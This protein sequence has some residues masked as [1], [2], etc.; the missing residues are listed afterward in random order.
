MGT[1]GRI[2]YVTP[3]LEEVDAHSP[4]TLDD[5]AADVLLAQPV[6]AL[7][8][9]AAIL[10]PQL[11]QH[12]IWMVNST[13]RGGGVAEMLPKI[14]HLLREL[15]VE[16]RWVV[17]HTPE[18]DFFPLTKRLHNAIHGEPCGPFTA[19]DRAL[20]DRVGKQLADELAPQMREGDILIVHDPQPAAM[21]AELRKRCRIRAIWRCHI[22]LERDTPATIEAWD[23]LRPYLSEYD[24]SVFSAPAYIPPYLAKNVSVIAPS[25][26]PMSHKNR[27]LPPVKLVGV[28][29][30]AGLFHSEHPVLTPPFPQQ[31][32]RLALDGQFRP[33][34][35]AESIGLL[36]RPVVTQVSRWDRLKG[37]SPLLRG[38]VELKQRTTEAAA[39]PERSRRRWEITRLVLAGPDPASIQ[40][41]PEAADALNEVIAEYRSLPR[42]I[43]QD[44]AILSL[45]ME[46]IKHNALI[47]NALQRA[48]SIVV[49]NSLREGFGLVV[50]EAMWKGTPVLGSSAYGIRQQ[51]RDGVDGYLIIDPSNPSC[52]RE[53][54]WKTLDAPHERE[55]FA[56]SAQQR[57]HQ[58]FLLFRQLTDW[59]QLL[60][61]LLTPA[62]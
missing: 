59:L 7:R 29:S 23:F 24:H 33:C 55:L 4:H 61:G 46:S 3:M 53:C 62:A 50:T 30:N 52:V 11:R 16:T 15:G 9:E 35:G 36:S 54:L 19:E 51:M 20:Y 37:W 18:Q 12:R 39:L 10:A 2:G 31:V 27:N 57:V 44:I 41:D 6:D 22:G 45:P 34:H 5:Y 60:A 38:F 49:Q 21:G 14:V 48:S 32:K 26:D 1:L 58:Q 8:R 42:H 13:A 43:Q 28:L 47:V 25:I 17:I 40:D 56:R